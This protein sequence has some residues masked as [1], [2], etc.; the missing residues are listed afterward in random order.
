LIT[1]RRIYA[2]GQV[3][4]LQMSAEAK[5]GLLTSRVELLHVARNAAVCTPH[6]SDPVTCLTT[7]ATRS[8]R[9]KQFG[10]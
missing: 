6:V 8:V 9:E 5:K 3:V 10:G 4:Q 7:Y 2:A 1:C